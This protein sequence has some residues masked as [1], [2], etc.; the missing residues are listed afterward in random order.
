M[1]IQ[2]RRKGDQLTGPRS[3]GRVHRYICLPEQLVDRDSAVVERRYRQPD[4]GPHQQLLAIDN[5]WQIEGLHHALGGHQGLRLFAFNQ[6]CERIA[7]QTGHR[8]VGTHC[9][10]EPLT[11][12]YQ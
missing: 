7:V 1:Q 9:I 12:L 6:Y 10:G 8:V 2:L 5:E 11:H 3:L 4:A